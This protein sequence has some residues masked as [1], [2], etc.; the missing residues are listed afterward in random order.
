MGE[1]Q[2]QWIKWKGRGNDN[3]N[4]NADDA[5][6]S[7]QSKKTELV[8]QRYKEECRLLGYAVDEL[9]DR[10]GHLQSKQNDHLDATTRRTELEDLE[11]IVLRVVR[12]TTQLASRTPVDLNT[13]D[14]PEESR[15]QILAQLD[16][17][18][19]LL[20]HVVLTLASWKIRLADSPGTTDLM[21]WEPIVYAQF[22]APDLFRA[23][24]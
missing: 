19:T 14:E 20:R 8:L 10:L 16:N 3:M 18:M 13:A 23:R 24:N 15:Q 7:T 1:I 21:T 9:I 6:G 5:D 17:L 11:S 2:N 22:L 12:I 4:H